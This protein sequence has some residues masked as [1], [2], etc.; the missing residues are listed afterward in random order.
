MCAICLFT[1]VLRFHDHPVYKQGTR[2]IVSL[3]ASG[4]EKERGMVTCTFSAVD[5][6][7]N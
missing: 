2:L 7:L 6:C 4:L 3:I 5:I 1:C